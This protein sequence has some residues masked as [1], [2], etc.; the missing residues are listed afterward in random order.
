MNAVLAS[1]CSA[2]RGLARVRGGLSWVMLLADRGSHDRL[3][4]PCTLFV[5]LVTGKGSW[6]SVKGIFVGHKCSQITRLNPV[7][8]AWCPKCPSASN[9]AAFQQTRLHRA[10]STLAGNPTMS[11]GSFILP[12][13]SKC[14]GSAQGQFQQSLTG[15]S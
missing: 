12:A 8:S 7:S 13:G 6:P 9:C 5:N 1:Q 14:Q 4:N 15:D 10:H 3:F 2:V 11:R